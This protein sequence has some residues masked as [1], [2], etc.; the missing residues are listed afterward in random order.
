MYPATVSRW[1]LCVCT[2]K[3]T[4][5]VAGDKEQTAFAAV[6]PAIL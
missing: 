2:K 6:R 4:D 1:F 5:A 3:T